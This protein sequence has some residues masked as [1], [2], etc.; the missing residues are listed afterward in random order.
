VVQD[1]R[2][3]ALL[4]FVKKMMDVVLGYSKDDIVMFRSLASRQYPTLVPLIDE[5]LRFAERSD[6]DAVVESSRTTKLKKSQIS[7]SSDS[8]NMH[9]F[10]LLREKKLFPS[11]YDLSDFAGRILPNM[12]RNRF[13]KLSRS[14]IAA[15]II[16]YL[17]TLDRR[18]RENLETSMREAMNSS[19]S[20]TADTRSFLSKWEK[21]IKGIEL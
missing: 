6:T 10:D 11:N 18:T 15:R 20:K 13:D 7:R 16:E 14:D 1:N 12:S 4:Q 19:P 8:A 5:Y 17:E 2:H 9:L 3:R 21:I